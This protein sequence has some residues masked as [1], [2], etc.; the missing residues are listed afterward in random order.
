MTEKDVIIILQKY[1][2][3]KSKLLG[4]RIHLTWDDGIDWSEAAP[5]AYRQEKTLEQEFLKELDKMRKVIEFNERQIEK[6][7]E[8]YAA[9]VL[10]QVV[11]DWLNLLTRRDA[12]II[13]YAYINHDYERAGGRYK[14][15]KNTE[16]ARMI[17]TSERV[18]RYVKSQSVKKIKDNI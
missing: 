15:L 13:F 2:T 16:I 9:G 8:Q 6:V 11:E 18:V 14:T 12:K 17:G 4:K 3:A 7:T 10:C 5:P 1:K